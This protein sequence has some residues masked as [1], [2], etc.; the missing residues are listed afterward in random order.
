MAWLRMRPT[1]PEELDKVDWRGRWIGGGPGE[2]GDEDEEGGEGGRGEAGDLFDGD[3]DDVE[4]GEGSESE[5]EDGECML[6]G[7]SA[8]LSVT[9]DSRC[10]QPLWPPRAR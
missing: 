8:S 5:E 2:D 9:D 3:K 10:F 4:D 7:L 1:A 6:P